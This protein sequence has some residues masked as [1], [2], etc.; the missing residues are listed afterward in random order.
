MALAGLALAVIA[1]CASPEVQARSF[2]DRRFPPGAP[3]ADLPGALEQRGYWRIATHCT[4]P[5]PFAT[6]ATCPADAGA[7]PPPAGTTCMVREK[8]YVLASG[9]YVCWTEKDG[10][11][12][13]TRADWLGG[14]LPPPA[15][16][17]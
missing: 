14:P 15:T 6:P 12:I 4:A 10:R 9:N 8:A 1:G 16:Q 5:V 2:L 17:P 3:S 11:I 13:A 7:A